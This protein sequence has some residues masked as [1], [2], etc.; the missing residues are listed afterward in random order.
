MRWGHQTQPEILRPTICPV[1]KICWDN[2]GAGFPSNLIASFPPK[3]Q[4]RVKGSYASDHR[5]TEECL[6]PFLLSSFLSVN[7]C[8]KLFGMISIEKPNTGFGTQRMKNSFQML[9]DGM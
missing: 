2:G 5:L 1:H 8:R 7:S 6:S 4:A 3:D 9:T